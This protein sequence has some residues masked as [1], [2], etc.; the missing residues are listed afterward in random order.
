MIFIVSMGVVFAAAVVAC[1]VVLR[2]RGGS[3][4]HGAPERAAAAR[5]LAQGLTMANF[6]SQNTGP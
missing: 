1:L 5:G 6:K 3:G 2:R 4:E